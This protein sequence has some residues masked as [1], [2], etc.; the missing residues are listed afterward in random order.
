VVQS[1][2][3]FEHKLLKNYFGLNQSVSIIELETLASPEYAACR[4]ARAH[5]LPPRLSLLQQQS[6]A[7]PSGGLR[8]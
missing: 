4:V 7:R 6:A 1:N 2:C 5:G 3:R 8:G